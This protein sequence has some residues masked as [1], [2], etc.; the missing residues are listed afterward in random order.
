MNTP[1]L[2]GRRVSVTLTLKDREPMTVKGWS[3][4]WE[5]LPL[6]A[7]RTPWE[8][9]AWQVTDPASGLRVLCGCDTRAD[10]LNR[11]ASLCRSIAGGDPVR[12]AA[13]FEKARAAAV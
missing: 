8:P 12:F 4:G 13:V 6:V 7:H 2:N 5:G 1:H 11:L 9:S 10:A 3:C